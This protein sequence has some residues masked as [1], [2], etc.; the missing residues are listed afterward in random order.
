MGYIDWQRIQTADVERISLD[1]DAAEE[2][3]N[4]LLNSDLS[5]SDGKLSEADTVVKLFN[6]T[7]AVLNI[8]GIQY[9]TAVDEMERLM[10]EKDGGRDGEAVLMAENQELK[11]EIAQ[12]QK[13]SGTG[14]KY[15]RGEIQQ[16]T[17]RIKMLT[18]ELNEA[19]RRLMKEQESF[20]RLTK[21]LKDKDQRYHDTKR[22]LERMQD[23]VKE[24]QRQFQSQRDSMIMRRSNADDVRDQMKEKNRELSRN[25]DEI[26]ELQK[27]NDRLQEEVKN[28]TKEMES[29]TKDMNE[30]A[31]DYSKLKGVLE[32]TDRVMEDM[33]KEREIL[34]SQVQDMEQQL[35]RKAEGDDDIMIAL[36]KKVAE[37]K[38]ILA[39]KDA[40][41]ESKG[42][43]LLSLQKQLHSAK[44]D[45]DRNTVIELMEA[46]DKKDE[47]I[48]DLKSRL[49]L[50]SK[51][52]DEVTGHIKTLKSQTKDGAPSLQQQRKIQSLNETLQQEQ[53]T[54]VRERER[55]I[56]IEQDIVEKDRQIAELVNR[57]IQYEKGQYGLTEAVQE[58][59][60]C[61]AQIRL[62]DRNIEDLTREINQLNLDFDDVHL[63]N[64]EMRD[65]LGIG[66]R[67]EL[68]VENIRRKRAVKEEQASA[69]NRVLQKE[70]ERLE[71]ERL[72]LKKALR[73]HAL[74]RGERAVE[75]GLS[76]LDMEPLDEE[77]VLSP[78]KSKIIKVIQ[79]P[80]P[81]PQRENVSSN[82][83]TQDSEV[84]VLQKM[85][86]EKEN[87]Q[88]KDENRQLE[89]A[90]R[91][92]KGAMDSGD[93]DINSPSLDKLVAM[94]EEKH[95]TGQYDTTV[96][97]KSQ[98][99]HLSGRNEELRL[100][101]RSAQLEINKTISE[102]DA[103]AQNIENLEK[104]N[105]A[106]REISQGIIKL[107]PLPLPEGIKPTSKDIIACLNEYIIQI[108]QEISN[109]ETL[110][111]EME[112]ALEDMRRKYSV[113]LHQQS[114]V[115]KEHLAVKVEKEEESKKYA[116]EKEELLLKKSQTDVR[117]Q[118]FDR[119]LDNLSTEPDQH[120]KMLTE[121]TRKI[122]VLKVNEKSLTRRYTILQDVE[123]NLRKQIDKLNKDFL[124]MEAAVT[125]KLGDLERHKETSTYKIT[126]L[127]KALEDT[128]PLSQLEVTNRQFN[129]LTAKYRDLLQRENSMMA[130]SSAFDTM[131]GELKS[132]QHREKTLKEK[133][134]LEKERAYALENTLNDLVTK[135]GRN[136]TPSEAAT[137][138]ISS[139]AR[140]LATLEMKELNE[141]ERA[142]HATIKYDQLRTLVA[143][144]ENRNAELEQKFAVT[145]KINLECQRVERDLRDQISNS[146]SAETNRSDRAR[147]IHL[148]E[149]HAT[150]QTECHKLKE[151]ADIAQHQTEAITMRHQ[152]QGKETESLRK[153]LYEL[154]METDEKTVIAKLHQH[155]VAL[156]ISEVTAVRKYEVTNTKVKKQDI[157]IARLNQTVDDKTEEIQH[158]RN[159][160]RSKIRFLKVIIQ[161]LRRQFS[162]ALPLGQQERFSETLRTL[163][164]K[165][166]SLESNL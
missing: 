37:W 25:L 120:K 71:E 17:E 78:S 107:N 61:R 7:K 77:V 11:A 95:A 28:A 146:V 74:D 124:D 42:K 153:Q 48:K 122:T 125:S 135:L 22:Q 112:S 19:D 8:K 18:E 49:D 90:L 157:Q 65:R 163:Q 91:E 127:Q 143:E 75:L 109:K 144:L 117:L 93:K 72:V 56:E 69:L 150:L 160:T 15:L 115:Y 1:E 43:E 88:L 155:I 152:S 149:S 31:D 137:A 134:L 35:V 108:L 44:M 6:V 53:V 36:N 14:D 2:Y 94:I 81:V 101:L 111:S 158:L 62:R 139:V 96:H 151:I 154:Q 110:C 104:E 140:K 39:A 57:M 76:A 131:Q 103:R 141:R 24:Y 148:E 80:D 66:S 58:I 118:E 105:G 114:I 27:A 79:Q 164:E 113:A 55:V 34:R 130:H 86:F 20:D 145:S 23:D 63:E 162:G 13:Y 38:D 82:I 9:E 68:D 159:E 156:Q 5:E 29:A 16:L 64:E 123:K 83:P 45:S 30:M 128:V 132:H 121:L 119:L 70:V 129:E 138:E 100:E 84:L 3:F 89:L 67:D 32:E 161:D 92:L 98:I 4:L 102:L 52:Y 87:T 10:A 21:D 26:S 59:K 142:N 116:D 46:N 50:A 73:K 106:L 133:L 47:Q 33:R 126:A 41:I 12:Y 60:D 85:Q 166:I 165:R 136:V 99:Q 97:L 147:I 51:D 54:I 40:D